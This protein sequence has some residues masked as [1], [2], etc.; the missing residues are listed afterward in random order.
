MSNDEQLTE[1]PLPN[2]LRVLYLPKPFESARKRFGWV[3]MVKEIANGQG[4]R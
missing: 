1:T 4:V 2:Y 3:L